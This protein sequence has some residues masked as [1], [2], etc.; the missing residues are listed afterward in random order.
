M[1]FVPYRTE[2]HSRSTRFWRIS[3]AERRGYGIGRGGT[4]GGGLSGDNLTTPGVGGSEPGPLHGLIERCAAGDKAA[5]RTLYD[6]QSARLN[7]VA[8]R[9]T[10]QASSAA[11]AV[12]DAFLQVWQQASR[13]DA[14][15]GS[16]EVW[17]PALVR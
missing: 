9:I 14:G 13:F 4:N 10:R 12:H 8:L 11:D 16:P 3:V 5:F 17:L 7:G 6:M 1:A 15:R 2:R